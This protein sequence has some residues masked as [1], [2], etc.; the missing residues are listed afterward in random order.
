MERPA[1]WFIT[2]PFGFA[3]FSRKP[4]GEC[5]GPYQ[6]RGSAG[7]LRAPAR[8]TPAISSDPAPARRLDSWRGK[9]SATGRGVD[10]ARHQVDESVDPDQ[11]DLVGQVGRGLGAGL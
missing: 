8:T 3:Q 7:N 5:S 11:V 6:R 10:P 2:W 4:A 1:R 9:K